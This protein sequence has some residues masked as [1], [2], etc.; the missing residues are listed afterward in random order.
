MRRRLLAF[1]LACAAGGA[2]IAAQAPPAPATPA[3]RPAPAAG[4]FPSADRT[5]GVKVF[6]EAPPVA[7]FETCPSVAGSAATIRK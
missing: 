6:A 3:A 1:A 5:C 7:V 4:T 2:S